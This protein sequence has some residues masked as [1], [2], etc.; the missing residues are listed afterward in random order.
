M[1]LL[2][3]ST[4]SPI[5]V[6]RPSRMGRPGRR[7]VTWI[8][9]KAIATIGLFL[10]TNFGCAKVP[11]TAETTPSEKSWFDFAKFPDAGFENV[12]AT[13]SNAMVLSDEP[14]LPVPSHD[15]YWRPEQSVL[16]YAQIDDQGATIR[17]VRQCR[18]K[19]EKEKDVRHQDWRVEWRDC[20]GVDFV[21]VPFQNLPM[22][23]H[24]MLSFRLS[25]GRA[26]V[27]S[28]EA[29]LEEGETYTP[30]AGA[31]RQYELIYILG[32]EPDLFGLRAEVRKDDLFLY[33]SRASETQSQELLKSVL[34]RVNAI[35]AQPE[36]YDSFTNNCTTNIVSHVQELRGDSFAADWRGK[37]PGHS[38]RMAYDMGLIDTELVFEEA[39]RR[40]WT[41]GRI[42]Q[43]LGQEDFSR[44]IRLAAAKS[45]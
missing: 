8:H 38:D 14:L 5:R 45:I 32:D 1:R 37:L 13:V 6:G 19:S 33:P 39:R 7:G 27:L 30:M 42:R 29:R 18:W 9:G 44:K 24:T 21:V 31:A 20:E 43:F 35:A 11:V 26:L 12:L 28:V 2:P 25:D 10:L 23:A 22:L 40:A 15:R 41:S 4:V 17:N 3:N 36:F 34:E 16:P